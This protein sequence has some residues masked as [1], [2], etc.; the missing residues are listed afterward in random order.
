M[1]EETTIWT[2]VA[3]IDE[4]GL[5]RGRCFL[6]GGGK[7][8]LFRLRNG[9]VRAVD[10]VC[11]HRAGPLSEGVIGGDVVVC[12]L[13]GYKFS[14]LDGRGL[15]NDFAVVSYPTQIRDGNIYIDLS[16]AASPADSAEK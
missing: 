16:S 8:A 3:R 6:V 11:P 4:I 9:V 2:R 7:V 15:D 14:L 10:A 5:G 12:P 1:R 13:H